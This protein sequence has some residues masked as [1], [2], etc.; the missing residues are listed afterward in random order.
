MKIAIDARFYGLENAGL[1]RYTMNLIAELQKIDTKN[2]YTLLLNEKWCKSLSLSPN[3]TKVLV[4]ARHYSVAEQREVPMV[5]KKINPDLTHFLHLNVPLWY[6]RPYVVTIHDLLMHSG[7]G[8][9]ATT[10]PLWK[11][12]IKRLGYRAVFDHAVKSAQKIIVPSKFVKSELEKTYPQVLDRISV[13]Y[14]GVS[15]QENHAKTSVRISDEYFLYV[16]NA[17]PHKNLKT[18]LS[19][20]SYLNV[21]REQS[22]K[23]VLVTPRDVFTERLKKEIEKTKTKHLVI[24]KSGVDDDELQSL[25]AHAKAFVYPSF[26]EGFGLPGLEAM[27]S[28]TRLVVSDIPVFHEVYED[29]ALYFNPHDV[30]SMSLVLLR[31]LNEKNEKRFG[32]LRK[33]SSFAKRYSWTAMAKETVKQYKSL[34]QV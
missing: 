1:G 24:L 32:A 11:F 21:K 26:S 20:I 29:N 5:L 23:L 34:S 33:A 30:E 9:E 10:L 12:L 4:R 8:K 2:E 31:V 14:E 3:F 19:A 28:N 17:Y 27:Q 6:N 25:Y 16:G 22:V 7:I 18:L 15:L 13:I